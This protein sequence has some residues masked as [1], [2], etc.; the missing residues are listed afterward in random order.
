M[1]TVEVQEAA[2]SIHW[3]NSWIGADV[4]TIFGIEISLRL[5]YKRLWFRTCYRC[6]AVGV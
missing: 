5:G 1:V 4:P 3:C 6:E 2:R